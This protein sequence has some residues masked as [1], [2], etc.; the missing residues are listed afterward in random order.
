MPLLAKCLLRIYV[1]FVDVTDLR[2]SADRVE[3]FFRDARGPAC[4]FLASVGS[5][6]STP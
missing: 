5:R 4:H 2:S 3:P 1:P 6:G